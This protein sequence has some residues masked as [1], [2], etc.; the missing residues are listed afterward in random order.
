MPQ[1]RDMVLQ[2]FTTWAAGQGIFIHDA[3]SLAYRP[4]MGTGI[5][6]KKTIK[7]STRNRVVEFVDS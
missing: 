4:S 3:I 5:I 1:S 7:V 6:A 2:E